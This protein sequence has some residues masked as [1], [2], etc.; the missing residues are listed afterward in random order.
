[1]RSAHS[2]RRR[3]AAA[4][5]TGVGTLAA[6]EVASAA[7]VSST[8]DLTT[9][10]ST[11]SSQGALFYQADPHPTGTGYIDPFVRIQMRGFERGY[12]TD[13]RPVEFETKDENQWTHSLLLANLDPVTIGSTQ[14]YKFSLDINE[15]GNA[16]GSKLSM[17]DFR[18]YLG[19]SPSLTGWNDGFGAN[20]V[21]VYDIDAGK[22]GNKTID[23]TV[24]L[25]Y[26]LGHGSGSG[27]MSVYVPVDL[28][29]RYGSQFKYVYLYS[30][31]GNPNQS[32]AGFEEWWAQTRTQVP[33]PPPPPPPPGAVPA[34]PALVLAL[35]G[36]GGLFFGRNLRRRAAA[37][38]A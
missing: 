8:I 33:P 4:I 29:Q 17:N 16:T 10:G 9:T 27:D 25:N 34:P 6:P 15:Q 31:F 36:F 2:F 24:E 3:L 28:F 18:V 23:V 7:Y 5:L 37:T 32:D 19:D 1:M 14:Y 20:S 38:T 22:Q 30:S 26:R 12:N 11:G 35:I 13:A 21:K